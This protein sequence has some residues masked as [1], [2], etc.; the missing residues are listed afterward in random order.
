MTPSFM[1]NR[2]NSRYA[3]DTRRTDVV[4]HEETLFST[5]AWEGNEALRIEPKGRK[6]GRKEKS[7]ICTVQDRS[8]YTS[9]VPMRRK[10]ENENAAVFMGN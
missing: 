5:R 2:M 1:M 3:A 6:E 10:R 9:R 8:V 4:L 7:A